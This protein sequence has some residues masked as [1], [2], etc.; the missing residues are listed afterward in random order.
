MKTLKNSGIDIN[1][2]KADLENILSLYTDKN[3][4]LVFNLNE[5][6]YLN[7]PSSCYE[8]IIVDHPIHWSTLSYKLY[9]TTRLAWLLLKL[10]FVPIDLM[11]KQIEPKTTVVY[12]SKSNVKDIIQGLT[13]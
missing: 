2:S 10:N 6:I 9:G 1:N 3:N 5:T 13:D 7:F 4:N 12:L 8:T 11:L